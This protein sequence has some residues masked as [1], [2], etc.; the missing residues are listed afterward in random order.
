MVRGGMFRLMHSVLLWLDRLLGRA[1]G[2]LMTQGT[3]AGNSP[4]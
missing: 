1:L 3:A 4:E 2:Q